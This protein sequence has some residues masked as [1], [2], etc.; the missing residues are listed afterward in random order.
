MHAPRDAQQGRIRERRV[1]RGGGR[2]RPR[3]IRGPVFGRLR[4]VGGHAAG[5]GHA[6]AVRVRP[7]VRRRVRRRVRLRA[8]VDL[9]AARPGRAQAVRRVVPSGEEP[10]VERSLHGAGHAQLSSHAARGRIPGGTEER[11]GELHGEGRRQ[12]EGGDPR[13]PLHGLRGDR[14]PVADRGAPL[15]ACRP[16]GRARPAQLRGPARLAREPG[17]HG[18]GEGQPRVPVRHLRERPRGRST[19]CSSTPSPRATTS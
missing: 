9:R 1:L 14:E 19:A 12:D 6:V 17:A 3:V 5:C 4:A 8:G 16:Q 13:G 15:P 11:D 7:Y 2:S 18:Q 10:P